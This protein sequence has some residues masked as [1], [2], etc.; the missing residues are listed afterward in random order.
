MADKPHIFDLN[1]DELA[2]LL[3]NWQLPA[4]RADQVIDWVYQH[5]VVNPENMANISKQ[6]RQILADRLRFTTSQVLRHQV[7]TDGVQKLLIQWPQHE[8]YAAAGSAGL[9][10][11]CVMIP[12]GESCTPD[13][14]TQGAKRKTACVSSQAGCP[15]GCTFCASGLGGLDGNLTSGQIVEQIWQLAVLP[16]VERITHVVFMG[17]GEPL[18]NFDQVVRAI[19]VLTATWGMGISGRRIT[20]STVGLPSQIR[21]LADLR[22]PITLAI[23][24]HAPNDQLRRKLIPWAQYVNINQLTE[25][26]RYYFDRTGREVTLE[27]I[28]LGGVNDQ[29]QHAKELVSVAKTLRA[30]VNLIQYNEVASLPFARPDSTQVN[31]FQTILRNAGVNTH[32]RASRG[33]DIAAACGQLHHEQTQM[34]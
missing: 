14:T 19:G 3:S 24:L 29:P 18:T 22:L 26:G 11:E 17:M 8:P 10:T 23:S 13:D 4:Y 12:A 25:A 34:T 32:T 7:A 16:N 31:R 21:R 28:L 9:Q 6:D 1:R 20:V 33:R 5:H 27:Y 15:V 30:N 2:H